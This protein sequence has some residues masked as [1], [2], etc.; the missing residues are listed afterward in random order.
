MFSVWMDMRTS[1]TVDQILLN[2]KRQQ[3]FLQSLCGLP[4]STYFSALK[5]KWLMDNVKGVKQ[6]MSEGRCLFGNIDSWIVWNLTG[7]VKGGLHITDVTNASRTMLMNIETLKWDPHLCKV[8]D[9]PMNIL[10]QIR[11]SSEIYGYISDVTKLAGIPISGVQLR[12]I[13]H[14][15]I[16]YVYV[17]F[18]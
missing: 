16:T 9:I 7:G 3:N 6:A 15:R 11:S 8:F 13:V 14:L 1:H 10:P 12:I 17:D 5:I 18:R 2:G 4:V